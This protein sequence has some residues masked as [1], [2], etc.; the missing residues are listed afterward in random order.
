M[1][2]T[3]Q[4]IHDRCPKRSRFLTGILAGLTALILLMKPAFSEPIIRPDE[5]HEGMVGY[6]RTVFHGTKIESFKVVVLGVLKK[7][8]ADND[9]ILVRIE[10][11]YLKKHGIGLVAGMSGSPVYFNGRL[12]GAVAYGWAFTPEPIAGITPIEAMLRA[13]KEGRNSSELAIGSPHSIRLPASLEAKVPGSPAAG[14]LTLEALPIPVAASGFDTS[15]LSKLDTM[16]PALHAVPG[17]S[18]LVGVK[19]DSFEPGQAVGAALMDG[20]M[21]LMATGTLTYRDGNR[22]LAFGHPFLFLGDVDFPMYE[23]YVHYILPSVQLPFK[24]ASPAREVGRVSQDRLYAI[25]GDLTHRARMVPMEITINEVERSFH[26]RYHVGLIRHPDFT[27]RLAA[28]AIEQA[29]LSSSKLI[30]GATAHYDM[31]LEF[32]GHPSLHIKNTVFSDQFIASMTSS[33]VLKPMMRVLENDF[34]KVG[35]SK[36]KVNVTIEQK[37]AAATIQKVTL[38]KHKLAP[39]EPL[40]MTV[41]LKPY[42]EKMV[43]KTFDVQIPS[44][45]QGSVMIGV[46][47]G[48]Y[49][50]QLRKL[51]YQPFPDPLNVDQVIS[52]IENS[53]PNDALI[54]RLTFPRRSINWAGE[55]LGNLPQ[56]YADLLKAAGTNPIVFHA[57]GTELSHDMPWVIVGTDM[58]EVTVEG[59]QEAPQ[60]IEKPQP[61]AIP[62]QSLPIP[63]PVED[64]KVN[65][66]SSALST[67]VSP[68]LTSSGTSSGNEEGK[69]NLESIGSLKE[70]QEGTL[71]DLAIST[72]GNLFLGPKVATSSPFEE[73]VLWVEARSG[74]NLYVG[75][76]NPGRIYRIAKDN[77]KKLFFDPHTVGVLSLATLPN[78]DLL[79]G[80]TGG[81]LFWLSEKGTVKRHWRFPENYI[82][83]IVPSKNLV[84]IATGSPLGRVYKIN[85]KESEPTPAVVY[86]ASQSHIISLSANADGTLYAGTAN[87]GLLIEIN[88]NGTSKTLY[89]L[90]EQAILSL[91]HDQDGNLLIG[92]SGKGK[93]YRYKPGQPLEKVAE[94]PEDDVTWLG[95]RG[96]QILAAT[97]IPARLYELG[98]NGNL[99]LLWDGKSNELVGLRGDEDGTHFNVSGNNA[100]LLE[101]LP[102]P[103][104]RGEFLTKVLDAGAKAEWGQLTWHG[105]VPA[106]TR[107]LVQTRSG[108]SSLPDATWSSWSE[109]YPIGGNAIASPASRY[110]QIKATLVKN[111][112]GETP[113]LSAIHLFWRAEN[114]PP[115]VSITSPASGDVIGPKSTLKGKVRDRDGDTLKVEIW[116]QSGNA[117]FEKAHSSFVPVPKSRGEEDLSVPLS[118]IHKDR[119]LELKV[120][121]SDA[122]SNGMKNALSFE[123][124]IKDLTFDSTPP[125]LTVTSSKN[126]H[127]TIHVEGVAHDSESY[128]KLVQ[129]RI[130]GGAWLDT[131]AEKGMFDSPDAPFSFEFDNL[132]EVKQ[133]EIRSI[134]AAENETIIHKDLKDL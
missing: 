48:A 125:T 134:D 54:V 87:S 36:I 121:V 84:Y 88:P 126:D 69:T 50:D 98:P 9:M 20:D 67:S 129:F 58:E 76:G 31:A 17:G 95:T 2:M 32:D 33:E 40:T 105:E 133:I 16:F 106:E 119:R 131:V 112:S 130:N 122:P 10:S 124:T 107:I 73:N 113:T 3:N 39:G 74:N 79:A 91:A 56:P 43:K 27:P 111:N 110:L 42:N 97:G 132:S 24:F 1:Q 62:P 28:L 94:L 68:S 38:N 101:I 35:I 116:T 75:T 71:N 108:N 13:G 49:E 118:S 60:G 12:A 37:L 6:G 90:D 120:I 66:Y 15:E 59:K 19:V 18:Q 128:V 23:S 86:N 93:V 30:G 25:G 63:P 104:N 4:S 82:W 96:D 5:I 51:M 61:P 72:N 55:D 81:K 26:H 102:S 8:L 46:S 64:S 70:W 53:P 45:V 47:G 103:P 78:G 7:A 117:S 99:S 65:S 85:L 34:E 11:P 89:D 115:S 52:Q 57:D 114:H 83:Q 44:D 41:F 127:G 29:I 80:A 22:I 123:T 77:D 100:A 109:P 14:G 21:S 92:T